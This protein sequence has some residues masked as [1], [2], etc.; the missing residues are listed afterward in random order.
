MLFDVVGLAILVL[1]FTMSLSIGA[2]D[3]ANALG[4]SYGSKAATLKMLLVLGAFF[5]WIGAAFCSSHLA[6]TLVD[7]L[8]P[9][10]KTVSYS[11][12]STMMF[13]VS[14]SSFLFI[15]TASKLGIP[16]SGTH[17]V[18]GSVIGAGLAEQS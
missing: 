14:L 11:T 6:G 7:N 13:G 4:T 5:E 16:I 17:T 8:L 1:S 2:N 10:L 3:A 15:F 12:K 9:D 18:I